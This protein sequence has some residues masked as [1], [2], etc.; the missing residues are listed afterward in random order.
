MLHGV[1]DKNRSVLQLHVS[2]LWYLLEA[3]DFHPKFKNTKANVP[4]VKLH[5]SR[6]Q[7][8]RTTL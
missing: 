8:N 6:A 4:A 3:A 1:N 2:V 5:A 7:K